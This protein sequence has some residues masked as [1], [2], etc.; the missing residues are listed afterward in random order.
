MFCCK[1]FLKQP[2][3]V[4]LQNAMHSVEYKRQAHAKPSNTRTKEA[5]CFIH[6]SLFTIEVTLE[7]QSSHESTMLTVSDIGG[8]KALLLY[9]PDTARVLS[10][11]SA[12][13]DTPPLVFFWFGRSVIPLRAVIFSNACLVPALNVAWISQASSS[14]MKGPQFTP[15]IINA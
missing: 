3:M 10:V 5:S 2:L 1:A 9:P 14:S 8:P 6:P 12:G 13:L 4:M 11:S 7:I 15:C